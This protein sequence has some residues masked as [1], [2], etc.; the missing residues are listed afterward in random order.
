MGT[1]VTPT[2]AA[3]ASAAS[4][5][6]LAS[7]RWPSSAAAP[8]Y[9]A[10][11]SAAVSAVME[12]KNARTA[13]RSALAQSRAI[14][15]CTLTAQRSQRNG[16][17]FHDI[18][19]N[20]IGGLR[21]FL[22]RGVARAGDDAMGENGNGQLLEIVGEAIVAAIQESAGLR[23]ALEHKS[24]PGT[25]AERKLLALAR[26][27]DDLEGVIVQTGVHLDVGDGVLHSENI[28]DV[29]DGIERIKRI[30]ANALAENFFFRF[31]RGIAHLDAHQETVE[32]RFGQRVRAVVLDGILRGDDEKGCGSG[33][34]LP[35][36]V[37]C[38]SFMASRSADCVRGVV[39][40]ISSAR[41]TLA[42]IGP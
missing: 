36:T 18:A 40:L 30:I 3:M 24:A 39:R 10:R 1:S 15:V 4:A 23:G 25:D 16:D 12:R 17:G 37:T 22:Q 21:F 41:T 38:A 8:E 2:H 32:L 9:S 28:A 42:K 7:A 13:G 11:R 19:K 26:A 5:V 20:G 33:S 31:V 6:V 27:I 14:V 29:R 35:S 34:V